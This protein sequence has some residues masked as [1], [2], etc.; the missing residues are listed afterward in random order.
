M[1]DAEQVGRHT[2]PQG[3]LTLGKG[4]SNN[5]KDE[6]CW[7]AHVVCVC[8]MQCS[9]YRASARIIGTSGG[10]EL[11]YTSTRGCTHLGCESLKAGMALPIHLC[12]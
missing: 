7:S 6:G 11:Q 3:Y 1:C 2:T 8:E 10:R 4:S 5:D 12:M 9:A